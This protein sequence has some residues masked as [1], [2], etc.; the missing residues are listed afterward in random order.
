MQERL[1]VRRREVRAGRPHV[2]GHVAGG[3]FEEVEPARA[4][5]LAGGCDGGD[6]VDTVVRIR[7]THDASA[8]ID[9]A[10]GRRQYAITPLARS[11]PQ[12]RDL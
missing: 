11:S 1:R 5:L 8:Q 2:R 12:A 4:V 3:Y 7:L 10:A 9:G 6:L